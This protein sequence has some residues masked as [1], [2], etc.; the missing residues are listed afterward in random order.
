MTCKDCEIIEMK[1]KEIRGENLV[2][3][4]PKCGKEE[5]VNTKDIK[6]SE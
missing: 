5:I 2:F 4:C 1:V 6:A 3:I